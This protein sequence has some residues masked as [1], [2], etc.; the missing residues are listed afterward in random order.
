MSAP[1]SHPRLVA[2]A[3]AV[4]TLLAGA[5]GAAPADPRAEARRRFDQG[6]ALVD[7]GEMGAALRAFEE[8]YALEPNPAVLYN[9]GQ[10]LRAL[11]RP[12]EALQALERYRAAG[13]LERARQMAVDQQLQELRAEVTRQAPPV[14][15]PPRPPATSEVEVHCL[16][17]GTRVFADGRWL[18]D[19][20]FHGRLTLAE[21][22][23]ELRFQSRTGSVELRSIRVA[24]GERLSQ[25]CTPPIPP[26]AAPPAEV[27]AV[28]PAPSRGP[29]PVV[30]V[31]SGGALLGGAL[32]LHLWNDE[33]HQSWERERDEAAALDNGAPGTLARK[34]ELNGR[35]SD[36]Q[37]TDKVVW[38]L[39]AAGGLLVSVGVT[40]WLTRLAGP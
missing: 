25:T 1:L 16:A 22:P 31:A 15:E 38:G 13:P 21:G 4:A 23:H 3:V 37:R 17:A 33:R 11:D 24:P 2:A 18:G 19:G 36:I 34:H 10:A 32:A 29:G 9:I 14:P 35:L 26:P 12:R 27:R 28:V 8:A 40:W 20:P 7:R 30:A 39:A 5:S 6:L